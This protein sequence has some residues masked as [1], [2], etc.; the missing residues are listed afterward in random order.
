MELPNPRF[1]GNALSEGAVYVTSNYSQKT[2]LI[3]LQGNLVDSS[4]EESETTVGM[5]DEE[6]TPKA[7]PTKP[8]VRRSS[9]M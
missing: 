4:S 6:D 5:E 7:A 3:C 8:V 1:T 9:R 2:E